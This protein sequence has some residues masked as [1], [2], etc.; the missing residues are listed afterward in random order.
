[1]NPQQLE[2]LEFRLLLEG[3]FEVYGYDFRDYA[4]A[5]LRRRIRHWLA[6]R[7]YPSL[8]AAQ[9]EILRDRAVFTSF[10]QGLTVNVS[11]MFRDPR[12]FRAL[13]EQIVPFLR[14]WPFVRIWVAGCAGG[15]EAYSL[16]ILLHEE[17]L[18]R[19][20]RIYATDINEAILDRARNGIFALR[21]MQTYTRN[22]QLAGGSGEF[23]D[24]YQ[25]RY[26]HAL[27]LPALRDNILF[28]PHNLAAD[29]EFGEMHLVLCRNVLIY[30]N[31]DL[32]ER[33]LRLFDTALTAG[34]FL[35][36]GMKETLEFRSLAASYTE[37]VK[38]L[39]IYRKEYPD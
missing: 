32:K 4:E 1:M 31:P 9:G 16:A 14:T 6:E 38:G 35:C 20:C 8:S 26:D 28:S 13:R 12:F 27:M 18:L 5:S 22:Y 23:A 39:R 19:R 25:A 11:E 24:Y 30:F 33:A 17:G 3:V 15:E 34:G 37:M 10:L 2:E 36:L 29:A 21:D 7:R